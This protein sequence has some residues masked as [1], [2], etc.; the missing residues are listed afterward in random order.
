[1]DEGELTVS[2][3]T[4]SV[5][6]KR[7]PGTHWTG[8]WVDPSAYLDAVTPQKNTLH[9]HQELNSDSPNI[10]PT[11]SIFWVK[12]DSTLSAMLAYIYQRIRGHIPEDCYFEQ[13]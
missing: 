9:P 2:H 5:F 10:Q 8:G 11:T 13:L 3:Y 4:C 7:A 12:T 1:M 6:W